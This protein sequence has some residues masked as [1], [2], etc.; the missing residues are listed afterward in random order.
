M[1]ALYK[2]TNPAIVKQ[3]VRSISSIAKNDY[4]DM[5]PNILTEVVHYLG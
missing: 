5:W 2:T 3:Y 4:P 1:G